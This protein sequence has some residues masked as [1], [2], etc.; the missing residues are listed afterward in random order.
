LPPAP[1]QL[2]IPSCGRALGHRRRGQRRAARPENG[3]IGGL[4]LSALPLDW[5]SLAARFG[6]TLPKEFT[7]RAPINYVSALK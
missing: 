7:D 2:P 4:L 5:P 1:G 3:G 6:A